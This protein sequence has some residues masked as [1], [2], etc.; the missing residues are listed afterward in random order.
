MHRMDAVVGGDIRLRMNAGLSD[1]RFSYGT[2]FGRVGLKYMPRRI[3]LSDGHSVV[4]RMPVGDD[5]EKFPKFFM[6]APGVDSVFAKVLSDDSFIG[7]RATAGDR[8]VAAVVVAFEGRVIVG[9]GTLRRRPECWMRHVGDI[10]L[11]VAE[12]HAQSNLKAIMAKR[13]SKC[14]VDCDIEVVQTQV[15]G[16]SGDEV[17]ELRQLGFRE[18]AVLA[19]MAKDELG[20]HHDVVLMVKEIA[21]FAQRMESL[22]QDITIPG[23]RASFEGVY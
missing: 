19:G 17:G 18:S 4:L 14:A 9:E 13:L 21:P 20:M 15:V 5:F 3:E 7:T 11:S 23:F 2:D 16:Q 6:I 12:S 22:I 10:H 1:Y 8:D